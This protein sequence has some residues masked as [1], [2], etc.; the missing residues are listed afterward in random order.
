M[1]FNKINAIYTLTEKLASL[2]LVM[3]ELRS[4]GWMTEFSFNPFLWANGNEWM[5]VR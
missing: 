1:Y 4:F 5:K 2:V 3:S